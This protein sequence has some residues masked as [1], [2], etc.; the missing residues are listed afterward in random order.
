LN[1]RKVPIPRTFHAF[2]SPGYRYLWPSSFIAYTCRWMLLTLLSWFVLE[3]T[4]SPWLVSLVGF[5]SMIPMFLLGMLGGVLADTV[6]RR[7]LLIATH[8]ASLAS[9]LAMTALLLSGAAMFW[10]AYPVVLVVGVAW[11]LDMPS[12]RSLMHDLVGR[13]GLNNAVA[14][15]SVGMAG[16]MMLA[17][18]LAGFLI[19]LVGVTGGLVTVAFLYLVSLAL[20][21]RLA[22][23]GGQVRGGGGAGLLHELVLGLRYVAGH[24]V[25]RSMLVITVVMNLLMFPYV[26][27]V[28]VMAR[29]VLHV[30]PDLMGILQAGTGV[31]SLVGAI[32]IASVLSIRY[33]GRLYLIGSGFSFV[34]L[35]VFSV[36]TRYAVSLPTLVI[37]GLGVAAFSTMQASMTM[38]V[39][40]EEMRGK[41]LGV[42]TLAI[43][44]GP[45]GAL[46]LGAVADLTSIGRALQLNAAAGLVCVIL[47]GLF[48]PALRERTPVVPRK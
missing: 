18:A 46:L 21:S 29:D 41:A 25:L 2:R 12:R 31:G 33:H 14:L 20:L 24:R 27:M 22:A 28:P 37:M 17:P 11:A 43:G 42:V 26:Q 8:A 38:L 4:D 15:D 19:T 40:T 48:M 32:F 5:F 34:A 13:A 3:T 47:V 23:P 35:L 30:G 36:S 6:D 1:G 44:A 7:R 16:S 10:H 9:G 45:F 39:S